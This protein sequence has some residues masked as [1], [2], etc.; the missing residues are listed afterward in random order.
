MNCPP[1]FSSASVM[2]YVV[3]M[4]F[5]IVT[6]VFAAL[7]VLHQ[8][9]ELVLD[10][11]QMGYLKARRG[12]VPK[13]LKG[14]IDVE[15]IDKAIAY[16]TDKLR[17]SVV[18]RLWDA[19][20]LWAMVGFGF[21]WLDALVEGLGWPPLPTGLLFFAALGC[22]LTAASLPFELWSVFGVE[23]RHG[24][25]RQGPAGFFVDKMKSVILGGL[26]AGGMLTALLVMMGRAERFW[27]LIAFAV[28][29]VFQLVVAWAFPVLIMP[30]FNTF[31]PV[32]GEL[33]QRIKKLA[34]D[35]NFPVDR[36]FTMDGSRRTAHSNAFIVGL[37]GAR[38][39]VFYDTLVEKISEPQLLAVLAHELGHFKLGHLRKRLIFSMAGMLAM[40][41]L[42]DLSKG[43]PSF[44]HG[45][46]FAAVSDHAALV[47]FGLMV[48]E[49]L[50]PAGWLGR[51]LSRRAERAAD[52]FAV[53]AVG[54]P[55]DLGDALVALTKQNLSSPGSHKLY[56]GYYNTHPGLK[57]RLASMRQY[58]QQR[59]KVSQSAEIDGA[60]SPEGADQ[61]NDVDGE[62]R[63][64]AQLADKGPV[65][66]IDEGKK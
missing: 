6:A 41:F 48:S 51:C 54:N 57:G 39:I 40:L 9:F 61:V 59:E 55:D 32:E 16:N 46:G 15:T 53:D 56:R 52:R 58:A 5:N 8:G 27:W 31:T 50:A 65:G 19:A 20:L 47:V 17:L 2:G 64:D 45:L 28:L 4:T 49:L 12:R 23:T 62:R 1:V 60:V 22:A 3:I 43:T 42:L 33:A 26:L 66:N 30:L 18:S 21:A 35:V 11:V 34:K 14:R 7:F 37:P 13:H 63:G 25:N 38:R 44:Y 36:V 29:A 10:F 24:F